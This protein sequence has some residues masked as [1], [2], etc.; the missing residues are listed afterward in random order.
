MQICASLRIW[1]SV[2][3]AIAFP[4]IFAGFL[5]CAQNKSKLVTATSEEEHQPGLFPD[6]P[7]LGG[8]FVLFLRAVEQLGPDV[9]RSLLW[10]LRRPTGSQCHESDETHGDPGEVHGTPG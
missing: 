2:I 5:G 7:A 3:G 8:V 10:R 9:T 6:M 4:L 1:K